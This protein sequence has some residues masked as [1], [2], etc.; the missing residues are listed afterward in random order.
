MASNPKSSSISV[1]FNDADRAFIEQYAKQK[2]IK[3]STAIKQAALDAAED[4][5]DRA[6]LIEA[7]T[8]FEK[9]TTT[10]SLD[11]VEKEL[12]KGQ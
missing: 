12:E 3:V 7:Q 8:A 6:A 9:D 11:Q 10:Y 1:R 5:F 2:G 4:E